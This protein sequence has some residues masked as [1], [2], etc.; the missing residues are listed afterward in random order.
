MIQHVTE[1]WLPKVWDDRGDVFEDVLLAGIVVY[2]LWLGFAHLGAP[3]V[4]RPLALR[5]LALLSIGLPGVAH[6]LFLSDDTL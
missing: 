1:F 6:D 3:R 2:T 4:Y 5:F